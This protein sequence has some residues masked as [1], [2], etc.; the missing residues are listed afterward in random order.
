MGCLFLGSGG[1]R[2]ERFGV[3]ATEFSLGDREREIR[4]L[5]DLWGGG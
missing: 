3:S 2:R 1:D 4:L 5:I